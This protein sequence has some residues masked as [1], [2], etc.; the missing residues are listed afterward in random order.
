MSIP[1]VQYCQQN[2]LVMLSIKYQPLSIF[3][4]TYQTK[5]LTT[6]LFS[7]QIQGRKIQYK[8]VFYLII[9]MIGIIQVNLSNFLTVNDS[10][11]ILS[12]S[13]YSYKGL[14]F[15]SIASILSGFTGVFVEYLYRCSDNKIKNKDKNDTVSKKLSQQQQWQRNIEQTLVSIFVL[16]FFCYF[17]NNTIKEIFFLSWNIYIFILCF[18]SSIGGIL[19][20]L[21]ILYADNIAK[22]ISMNF[23]IVLCS[24]LSY[25]LFQTPITQSFV[26]GV[27]QVCSVLF[28]LLLFV[29]IDLV[30][31]IVLI[32]I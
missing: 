22:A 26:F 30:F 29:F 3:Q 14:Q 23:S 25:I 5:I 13:K 16:F 1:A 12:N 27:V 7:Y 17:Q 18:L 31:L 28:C 11:K 19:V 4:L 9:L 8:Q 24:I 21:V 32:L 10:I 6:V 15:V 20:S 2:T